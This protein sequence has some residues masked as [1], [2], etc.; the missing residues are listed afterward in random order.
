MRDITGEIYKLANTKDDKI[1]INF[2][3]LDLNE[4]MQGHK[5]G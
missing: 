4:T 5:A 2:T 3:I 1:Y